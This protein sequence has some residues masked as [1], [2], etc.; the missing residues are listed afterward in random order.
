MRLIL[1]LGVALMTLVVLALGA[2][3]LIPAERIAALAARELEARTGRAITIAGPVK[4]SIWPV[5]GVETGPVTIAN[6]DWSQEGPFLAAEGLDLGVDL[7]SLFSGDVVIEKLVLTAPEVR[8]ERSAEGAANWDFATGGEGAADFSAALVR[9]ELRD[10]HI[11]YLDHRTGETREFSGLS[12]TAAMP[13]AGGTLEASLSAEVNGQALVLD[14]AT[15]DGA[16]ALAGRVV[17]L[18]AA[19]AAG[20]AR[21]DF[22]GRAGGSPFGAEGTLAADLGDPRA[23]AALLGR[24]ALDLPEGLGS[25]EMA[26]EGQLTLAPEGSLHLR[27][28]RLTLDGNNLSGEADVTFA[29]PRPKLVAR[30]AAGTLSLPG[31]AGAGGSEGGEGWSPAPLG[32]DGLGALDAEIA[33]AADSLSLGAMVLAPVDLRMTLDR[34]RLATDIRRLGLFGGGVTGEFV[35]NDRDGL[36]VG[37]KL[38]LTGLDLQAALAALEVTRRLSGKGTAELSFL[39]V[40]ESLA[41]IMASLRGEGR[42]DLGPGDY[43]GLDLAAILRA[44]D[45]AVEGDGKTDFQRVTGSFTI[46]G[47]VLRNR[48][49]VLEGPGIAATGEGKLGL[50]AQTI[51][52][53]IAATALAGADGTGGIGVPLLVTG[54]WAA[55]RLTLDLKALAD[56]ELAE[57]KAALEAKARAA[58]EAAEAK[59]REKLKKET[60]IEAQEGET[61]EDAAR[62][63]AS[64]ALEE[65][66]GRLLEGLTGQGD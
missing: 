19:L 10:G 39:G 15:E 7:M 61:L 21:M 31:S 58:A 42:I 50:G 35:L 28:G 57:E 49:L 47:G 51:D 23:L 36:S 4:P 26:L 11:L 16:G 5:L 20:A 38:A 25:R 24:E 66:A 12:L 40:G 2:V 13:Q 52:Y 3:A 30:L 37:G 62:R 14:L 60:G 63:R 34:A 43:A 59:L 45:P 33:L 48:D 41:A 32:I 1:R 54:P 8:L 29:G 65:E 53:R 44:L 9:A 55:P 6:A 22:A 46:E 56:R 18:E 17:P 27:G 64:E